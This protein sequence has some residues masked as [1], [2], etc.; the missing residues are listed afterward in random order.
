MKRQTLLWAV[1]LLLISFVASA[2]GQ[3]NWQRQGPLPADRSAKNVFA[4]SPDKAFFVGE[5]KLT[6]QTDSAG[7]SWTVHNLLDWG[8]DPYY[9]VYFMSPMTGIITGNNEAL[10][11]E[12]G[13]QTWNPV[14]FFGGSW[15]F[16]DFIDENVG[17]AGANGA[18]A[19]TTDGGRTWTV[20]SGYPN[21]PVMFGM[22]FRDAD[23]GLACGLIAG[24]GDEGIYKT[25]DGGRTWV[26]KANGAANDVVWISPSRAIADFSTTMRQSFDGGETWQTVFGGIQT[27]LVSMT[28]AGG[29][30]V[31]LGVSGGGDVWRSVDG[32]FTWQQ[33]FD[34]PGS[35]PD[36][37]EISFSDELH[38]WIVG[39]GGFYYY[40]SDGGITWIQKNSGCTDQILDIQMLDP[41]YG[42]AVGHNGYVFRTTNG[43]SFWE[44][45]KLE[46]TGQIWGRDEGLSAVDVVDADF[47]VA[48][49]FGGVVFKSNDGGRNWTSIGY[50][51]LS[52][53]LYI[54][55][56]D[57]IDHNLGYVYGIN[58][59]VDQKFLFRTRDGGATWEWVDM[60]DIG[61][62]TTAQF[63][64]ADYGWLTADNNFGWRTINGGLSWI[65]F[66]MPT[67]FSGPEVSKVRFLDRNVGWVVGWDG[68][69]GKTANGGV[70][71]TL[72]DLGTTTD[73]LFDVVPVSTTEIWLCGREHWSSAGVVYRTT[74]GGQSWTRQVVTDWF[75]YPYRMSVLPSGDAWFAG[76]AG[77][78]FR[79]VM[80][81]V[82]VRPSSYQLQAGTWVSGQLS[83]LHESDDSYLVANAAV[84]R[85]RSSDPIV[86]LLDGIAPIANPSSLQFQFESHATRDNPLKIDLW[87]YAE[88]RWETLSASAASLTDTTVTVSVPGLTSM[89]IEPGSRAMRARVRW[90]NMHSTTPLRASIDLAIWK[91]VQ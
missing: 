32:G 33:T 78:I 62:G 50:P 38:G 18:C 39:P 82:E 77:S 53:D 81:A 43:G 28:K 11:T 69:V 88:T 27:G 80:E 57:F 63:I 17:F 25:V 79:R 73:H 86:L 2:Y 56:V 42:L 71:W 52:G 9:A 24:T 85:S 10:R 31:V 19:A 23:V 48:A 26:K 65:P 34:G 91:V 55:D 7:A 49:G 6:L 83:S 45:Q 29:G 37:W 51:K 14:S 3:I 15:S 76:Y 16:L 40:S 84:L 75:Y 8:T 64:D 47:A 44:I 35:L 68:Y 46:V 66:Q 21:C 90:S 60:G 74:N 89:F 67:Y 58:Y 5:N 72:V 61:G 20:R 36:I 59:V 1:C 13:G 22:D 4:I 30:N 41:S 87:N 12:D 54:F 70:S